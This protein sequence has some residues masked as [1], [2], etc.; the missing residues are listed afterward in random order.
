MRLASV[1]AAARCS[2]CGHTGADLQCQQLSRALHAVDRVRATFF[3]RMRVH[4]RGFRPRAMRRLPVSWPAM[5]TRSH[6][7]LAIQPGSPRWP[8]RPVP[9]CTP[10]MRPIPAA[11][12][13]CSLRSTETSPSST[14]ASST[15]QR[16]PGPIVDVDR[17]QA[18]N[19]LLISSY[20]GL[21]V[22]QAAVQRM[23]PHG[24]GTILLIG[25]SASVKGFPHGR[26]GHGQ[27]RAARPGPIHS[28]R[29]GAEGDPRGALCHRWRSAQCRVSPRR[30]GPTRCPIAISIPC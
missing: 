11:S 25:A 9:L 7:L 29:V 17:E 8:L 3:A 23:L 15:R 20:G 27:V 21:L 24:A 18:R 30:W 12:I 2:V 26:V 19:A 10:A 14:C 1:Y 28:P 22:A 6:W 5:A 13:A 16:A 4:V